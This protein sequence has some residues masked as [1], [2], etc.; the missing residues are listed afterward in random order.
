MAR[1]IANPT[2]LDVNILCD[3]DTAIPLPNP[4][5]GG[6]PL[7]IGA[8]FQVVDNNLSATANH[9]TIT[10]PIGSTSPTVTSTISTNGGSQTFIWMGNAYTLG[11]T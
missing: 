9:I 5:T 1:Y 11:I 8:E 6:G 3:T 10:G 7:A 2:Y 4:N